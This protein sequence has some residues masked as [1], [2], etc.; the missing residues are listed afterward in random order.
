MYTKGL[1]ASRRLKPGVDLPAWFV[2]NMLEL[3]DKF[4][5]VYHKWSLMWDDVMNYH[6]GYLDHP[7]FSIHEEHMDT[8]WGWPLTDGEGR[9]VP[10]EKW[11]IWRKVN[12]TGYYHVIDLSSTSGEHL[13]KVLDILYHQAKFHDKGR[14]ALIEDMKETQAAAEKKKEDSSKEKWEYLQDHNK[15]LLKEAMENFGRDKTAPTNPTKDIIFSYANQKNHTK[16]VRP[17]TDKD[18]GLLGWDDVED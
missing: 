4:H 2:N 7:R 14:Q 3:D 9:P 15:P 1:S 5:F 13:V 17:L 10:E 8:C 16:I 11:H 12:D 6:T 18:V